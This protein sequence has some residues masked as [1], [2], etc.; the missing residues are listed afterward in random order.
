MSQ[1]TLTYSFINDLFHNS[2]SDP[3]SISVEVSP[4]QHAP[5]LTIRKMLPVQNSM[6]LYP[7]SFK[8]LL[9][10]IDEVVSNRRHMNISRFVR[11]Y[12]ST[13]HKHYYRYRSALCWFLG[14]AGTSYSKCQTTL[15]SVKIKCFQINRYIV[16]AIHF[17]IYVVVICEWWAQF[18][19]PHTDHHHNRVISEAHQDHSK[20]TLHCSVFQT[21]CLRLLPLAQQHVFDEGISIPSAEP[22]AL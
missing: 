16:I 19:G 9:T 15:W 8:I 18:I 13:G 6:I 4:F 2:V 7:Q 14:T 5:N 12:D 3:C 1:Q 21:A 10:N 11:Q 22:H 17:H 20:G